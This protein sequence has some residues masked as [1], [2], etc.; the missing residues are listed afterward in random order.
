MRRDDQYEF[1]AKMIFYSIIAL[2]TLLA[3]SAPF[4]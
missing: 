1:S 4:N 2:G 3:V